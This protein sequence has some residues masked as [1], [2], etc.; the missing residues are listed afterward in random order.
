MKK[1]ALKRIMKDQRSLHSLGKPVATGRGFSRIEFYDDYGAECS[2]QQSSN[3][4][5]NCLWLGVDDAKPQV[6]AQE[7]HLAGVKTNETT[8]WVPFPIPDQVFL[9]TRMHLN[10]RQVKALIAT[11]QGWLD[12]GELK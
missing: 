11:L 1:S 4:E 7:A 5:R 8:G 3:G 12:T 2:L 9:S 10:E 6:L